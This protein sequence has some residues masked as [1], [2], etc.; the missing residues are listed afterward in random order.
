VKRTALAY[1]LAIAA[2]GVV[3]GCRLA[4]RGVLGDAAPLLPFIPAVLLAAWYGGLGP[5]LLATALSAAAAAFFLLPSHNGFRIDEA[6]DVVRTTVF[7]GVG[8]LLTWFCASLRRNT[9]ERKRT[10]DAADSARRQLELVTSCMAAPVTRCS[11]DFKYVW[12][13]KACADWLGRSPEEINGRPIAEIIGRETFEQLRPQFERVLRGETVRYEDQVQY[14][15]IGRRWISAV[16]TPTRDA[17][18]EIDGW[19]AVI[20]DIDDRIKAQQHNEETA[21]KTQEI[22]KL[23]HSIGS[24]GHWEW[25][26]QTD[27]N[28]WSPEIEALYG[29]PPGGFAGGYDGWVKLLH[30][31]DIDNAAADVQQALET[32]KYFTEFRVVWPDGSVHWL[33]A[34]A[35]VFHD[36]QGKPLRIAGVNMDVTERK[37]I[38]EALKD[39]DRRKD[40]FLATLAHELRNPLAPLR[41]GLEL[42]KLAGGDEAVVGRTREMMERQLGHM[43][44]LVDDLLDLSRISRGR[45]EL[46]RE[47]IELTKIVRHAV[48]TSRPLIEQTGQEFTI[49]LAPEPI[50]V[51]ADVTRLAQVFSNLLNNAAKYT[52][53]DGRIS[54]AVERQ[55]SDA[56][57]CVRDT[58]AGIPPEMLPEVF[59]MFA[60]VDRSQQRASSGLGIGLSLVKALVELHGGSVEARSDGP[61]KGS[62]FVVRLPVLL[63]P[64]VAPA[65]Q[66]GAASTAVIPRRRILI[67]DDN[68]D[69]AISLATVLNILGHRTQV[70]FDGV[71]ALETARDFQPD[72]VLLDIGMPKLNGHDTARRLRQEP[73]GRDIVLVAVTGWG[74]D[75]D[76]QRSQDA[77]FNFH[78]VKPVD[79]AALEQILAEMP[80][81]VA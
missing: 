59:E 13:S 70:A 24:I 69:T 55:G 19:V 71:E 14:P 17:R 62:E 47:R 68:R 26:A 40:Q 53:R 72:V 2:V 23:V 28:R 50:V 78:L 16:Y 58:G 25:N 81:T 32:G 61:G 80:V 27:E 21:R 34:R 18:D 44:R 46:R 29:L 31:D 65:P 11:R 22:F 57:V 33:E 39:A 7:V 56:V 63:T 37:R 76:R 1:G 67:V 79:P 48:E 8:A 77:G 74:Q 30:P 41:N 52:P 54:L 73:R 20:I 42:I 6:S 5:G 49:T 4:L 45:I 75:D 36:E 60:Q 66:P 51:D 9:T 3:V 12:V 43:V 10:Q 38:E 15:G 64:T 35:K